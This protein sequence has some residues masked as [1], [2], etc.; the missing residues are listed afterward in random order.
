MTAIL[1]CAFGNA[2]ALRLLTGA[3]RKYAG[4]ALVVEAETADDALYELDTRKIDAFVVGA[5][6]DGGEALSLARTVYERFPETPVLIVSDA[7]ADAKELLQAFA[8]RARGFLVRPDEKSIVNEFADLKIGARET[9]NE[10]KTPVEVR[11][12]GNFDVLKDH[13]PVRFTRAKAKEMLAYLIY[14]RGTG[15]S[16]SELIV[17]LWEDKDVDRTTRSMFHNVLAELKKSLTD[18][19]IG[20]VLLCERNCYRVVKERFACDYFD[21]LDGKEEAKDLFIGEFMYG[22][23]WAEVVCGDLQA[24]REKR[25]R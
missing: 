20:D 7:N 2:K 13:K 17:N 6:A 14:R 18:S 21:Y 15:V 4:D 10:P 11:T 1:C 9:V 25:Y 23:E 5:Q 22:Y 16:A 3:A 8:A 19:G 12:F 24:I